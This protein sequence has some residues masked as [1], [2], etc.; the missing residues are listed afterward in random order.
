MSVR[1]TIGGLE[2]QAVNG[3]T[4]DKRPPLVNFDELSALA[5]LAWGMVR[6]GGVSSANLSRV[7]RIAK[8]ELD[9]AGGLDAVR[10]AL[11]ERLV[12]PPAALENERRERPAEARSRSAS[13]AS[14]LAPGEL[15][16][17]ALGRGRGGG[18]VAILGSGPTPPPAGAVLVCTAPGSELDAALS[19]AAALVVETGTVSARPVRAARAAG[20]P[21]V[22]LAGAT[23]RLRAGTEVVV[24]GDRGTVSPKPE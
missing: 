7:G 2:W 24:D 18:P 19:A 13:A 1:L 15:A 11:A 12:S 5:T 21:V 17:T 8:D 20:I 10:G 9:R 4:G 3:S 14:A 6:R 16:G 23:T 22:R